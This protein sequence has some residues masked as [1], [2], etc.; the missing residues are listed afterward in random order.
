MAIAFRDTAKTIT[1]NLA[2]SVAVTIPATVQTGDVLVFVAQS[3]FLTTLGT[4]A[5]WTAAGAQVDATSSSARMFYR[6]AQPGDAGATVTSTV[7]T[8]SGRLL[9]FVEAYSG[10]DSSAPVN[11][12]AGLAAASST[13]SHTTST[14]TTTVDGCWVLQCLVEK[15]TSTTSITSPAGTTR[16]ETALPTPV[17]GQSDGAFVDSNAAVGAGSA[18]GGT[19]TTDVASA[20]AQK[21]TL[22]LAPAQQVARPATDI[23]TTGWTKTGASTYSSQIDEAVLDTADYVESPVNPTSS[24]FETKLG[25]L[26]DP[27]VDTGFVITVVLEAVGA[28]TSTA[29]VGLYQ[30]TTL[31]AS[32]TQSPVASTPT[33]YNFS[34]SALQASAITNFSDLRIRVTATAA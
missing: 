4:P 31:I 21:F 16:R 3:G 20:N 32:F 27:G 18:G 2:T 8:G 24:V 29:V 30:T 25:P 12:Y 5:G 17:A 22:A 9:G 15:S 28:A 26:S 34:L 23:T 13:T 14:V 10:A 6:V 33:V 7:S 11:A 1:A 19:F